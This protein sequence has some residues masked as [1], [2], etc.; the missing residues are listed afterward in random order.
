MELVEL[1]KNEGIEVTFWL[2]NEKFESID[3]SKLC[4]WPFERA[5]ISSDMRI[6]PCC[7]IANPEIYELGDANKFLEIWNGKTYQEF[8]KNH[9]NRN[10]PDICF[11]CYLNVEN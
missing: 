9:I 2:S 4:P 11:D 7:M 6:V 3:P 1:G 8:R 5:L 10:I